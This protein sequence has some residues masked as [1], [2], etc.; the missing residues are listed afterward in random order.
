VMAGLARAVG[1]GV[2]VGV[3]RGSSGFVNVLSLLHL[4]AEDVS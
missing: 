3:A 4:L 2:G 1:L